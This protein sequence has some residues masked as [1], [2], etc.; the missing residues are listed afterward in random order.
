MVQSRSLSDYVVRNEA[1]EKIFHFFAIL[2]RIVNLFNDK[3]VGLLIYN[4]P[5]WTLPYGPSYGRSNSL[6]ANLCAVKDRPKGS[7]HG[8]AE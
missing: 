7:A 3:S 5:P 4:V 1:S 6:P 8:C 2:R